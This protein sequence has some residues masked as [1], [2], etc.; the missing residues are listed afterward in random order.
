MQIHLVDDDPSVLDST[1]FLLE[2][3]GYQVTT[4]SDSVKFVQNAPHFVPGIV[5]LDMKM[6]LMDGKQVHQYLSKIQSTLAVIIM[7]AYAD[8]PMA[9][10]ELKQGAVDFLQKPVDFEHLRAT[11]Q[12]AEQRTLSNYEKQKIKQDYHTLSPKQHEILALIIQGKINREIAQQLNIAIRTV[13]VH[14]AQIMQ[15]MNAKTLAELIY[16]R[17]LLD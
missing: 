16:K 8:V 13:E 17:S 1:Q 5:L 14:R 3:L 15:K 6:P 9:V 4:W 12:I 10:S 2:Q 11:L 7:T